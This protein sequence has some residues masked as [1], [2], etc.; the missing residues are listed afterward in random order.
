MPQPNDSITV[1]PGAGATV[2]T[3]TVQGKEFQVVM[4]ADDSG[5]FAQTQPTYAWW[6]P[7][8]AAG[9]SKMYAD[10]FNASTGQVE[11]RGLWAIPRSDVAIVGVTGLEVQLWRT[12]TVGTT[13]GTGQTFLYNSTTP[14]GSTGFHTVTPYNT[15]N[16]TLSTGITARA[17]PSTAGAGAAKSAF[18]W[19]QFCFTEET[20]AATYIS[21]FTNLLPVG[22]F[23]QKITLNS[24][25]GLLIQQGTV[26][27]TVATMAFLG[28]FSVST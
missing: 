25:E 13:S 23:G 8:A 1:T 19:A 27:S 21:A 12:S 20:N 17:L 22:L 5:Y 15:P 16:P 7:G 26:G 9:V 3:H 2:A 28:Q 11:F 6:V 14:T 18:Y 10:F 24:S 4:L